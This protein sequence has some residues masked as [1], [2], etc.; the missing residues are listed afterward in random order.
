MKN[1]DQKDLIKRSLLIGALWW[2]KSVG[3]DV[4]LAGQTG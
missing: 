2:L 3:L 4:R 1:A